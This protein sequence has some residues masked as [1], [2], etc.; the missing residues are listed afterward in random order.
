M[1]ADWNIED[2]RTS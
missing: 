2:L 1:S